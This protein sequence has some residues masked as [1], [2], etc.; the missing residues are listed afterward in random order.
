MG[1]ALQECHLRKEGTILHRDLKPAN[2]FLDDKNDVKLG[3]FG[4]ARML[5]SASLF[6]RTHVGTPY[7]MS[8][9][10]IGKKAYNERSDIWAL[11]CI[12]YEMACLHTPFEAQNEPALAAKIKAGRIHKLPS[13]YSDALARAIYSM[14]QVDMSKRPKIQELLALPQVAMR[15]K[16]L[17]TENKGDRT[18]RTI[19][20]KQETRPPTTATTTTTTKTTQAARPTT[21]NPSA[22]AAVAAQAAPTYVRPAA[23]AGQRPATAHAEVKRDQPREDRASKAK[24]EEAARKDAELTNKERELEKRERQLALEEKVLE[25]REKNTYLFYF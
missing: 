19:Q 20:Q 1:L 21:A 15:L 9:E 14:L 10:Q 4:L 18:D 2:V 7:Y 25:R 22:A 16:K 13:C 8:P 11:G 12:L 24:E 17:S 3:D 23:P 6:A 5:G